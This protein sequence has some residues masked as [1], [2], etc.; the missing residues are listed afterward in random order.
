MAIGLFDIHGCVG[1]NPNLEITSPVFDKIVIEFP[2]IENPAQTKTFEISVKRKSEDDIY[3][4]KAILNGERWN[5]FR[6]PVSKFF[7]GGKL[8]IELGDT[9]NENWGLK[10]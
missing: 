2:S 3:I 8:E 6:F 10:L 7:T 9:P 5:S 4:Q 1:E